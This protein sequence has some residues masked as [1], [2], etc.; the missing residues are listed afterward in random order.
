VFVSVYLNLPPE[1]SE[2]EAVQRVAER[3]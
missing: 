1:L 2:A 3:F